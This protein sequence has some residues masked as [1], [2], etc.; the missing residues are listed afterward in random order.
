MPISR[1]LADIPLSPEQH[2]VLELAFRHAIRKIGL[3]DRDDPIC[4]LVAKKMVD[5]HRQGV[6]D[7]I[8]LTE[9]TIRQVSPPK[10]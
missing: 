1:L 5:L 2:H 3:V 7:A 8:A 4:V 6:T 10:E 9:L